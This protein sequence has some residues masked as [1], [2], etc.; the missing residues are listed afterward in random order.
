MKRNTRTLLLS[1]TMLVALLEL[2]YAIPFVGGS[3]IISLG[4]QPLLFNAF[5]YFILTL[6]LLV[7][8]QNTIRP[9]VAFTIIGLIGSFIA[10]IPFVGFFIH[11]ILLCMML[12][13]IFIIFNTP[14]YLPNKNARVIYEKDR[15]K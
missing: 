15:L 13:L 7:D 4:W 14:I 6:I 1:L 10:F 5:L 3:I 9:M 11:W 12:V 2:I 8:T